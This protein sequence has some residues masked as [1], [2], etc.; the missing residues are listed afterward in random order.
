MKDTQKTETQLIDKL[1]ELHQHV[2]IQEERNPLEEQLQKFMVAVEQNP[3]SIMITDIHGTIEYVNP[4]FTEITGY[5][6][7]EVMGK[8]PRIFKSGQTTTEEYAALWKAITSGVSWHG[9]FYNRKKNGDLYWETVSISPVTNNQGAITHF[10]A[11]KEDLTYRNGVEE[12]LEK[13]R[14]LLRAVVDN[15]PDQIFVHDRDCRFVLNNLSDARVIGVSD[16]TLLLGKSDMDFYPPELASRYQANDR[17]VMETDQPLMVEE[18]PSVTAGGQK[19]W[20]NAIKIPFHDNDGKVI[21]LVG[22]ARDVTKRKLA[23]DELF[24]SRQMLQLVVENIPMLAFWKDSNL[25]YMGCNQAFATQVGLASPSEIVGKTDF[26][27]PWKEFA[28]L[29]RDDDQRV[30]DTD[31]PKLGFEEPSLQ[32]DSSQ[33][34]G[35]TNKIPL[36]DRDGKVIGLLVTS[37]DI[38]E[39][40]LAEQEIEKANEKLI[41]WVNDLEI[42]NQEANLLRQMGDL[43]QVS[44]EREEYFTIIREYIPQLFPNTSGALFIQNNSQS[45]VEA[46]TV[47]GDHLQSDSSFAPSDCWAMRRGQIY[48][49]NASKPGLNCRHIKKPFTGRYIEVP[50]MASGEMIGVLHI[51]E[52]EE[53]F[54]EDTIQDLAHSL[55]DHLSL[56]L[57]NLKLR[58]TLRIQSIRDALTGLFNRRYMEESLAR[59]IPRA[60]RK[61]TPV[62][63]I[64][65]DIDHFR[66]FNNTYGHEAGDVV[67]REIGAQL[68]NQ[69]RGEDITCR[70]GGEEFILILPEANQEVT[71]ARAERIREAIKSIRVE[72]HRQPLGVISVSLGVAIFPEHSSTVE[73]ILEKADEALYMA[74]HNGR[75]RVE[76]ASIS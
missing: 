55:A 69:I 62:G 19:R 25:V 8:N 71:V 76:I 46:M 20:V 12:T 38:T 4:M 43:L 49:G 27:L 63:I 48:H 29:Y 5:S 75:D 24:R 17:Q 13:E 53:I 58:E 1:S 10:V 21:G 36:H 18:E 60:M 73:G 40:R 66:D 11:I 7:K 52:G 9:K 54:P 6:L 23:E 59:E 30:I 41:S 61:N 16:P 22:I 15:I 57:S 44:N 65:L 35:R 28:H 51:E 33:N 32:A 45:S 2:S 64:M 31:T 3:T 67:L 39:R 42:R 70:Y 26:D 14:R 34:W 37:E 47:W 72:Y 56:S 74:K 68:Q 50:M